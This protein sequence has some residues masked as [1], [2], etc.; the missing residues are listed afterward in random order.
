MAQLMIHK[1]TSACSVTQFQ[2]AHTSHIQE[3]FINILVKLVVIC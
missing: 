3:H 2:H 1:L